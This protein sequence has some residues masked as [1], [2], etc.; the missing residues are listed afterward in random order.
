MVKKERKSAQRTRRRKRKTYIAETR[1]D[2]RGPDGAV[3]GLE[4]RLERPTKTTHAWVT[5]FQIKTDL[6]ATHEF[7]GVGASSFQSLTLAL[8]MVGLQLRAVASELSYTLDEYGESQVERLI[9]LG[10]DSFGKLP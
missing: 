5:S 6:G 10:P 8:A 2:A 1:F 7:V 4:V 9:A 3:T